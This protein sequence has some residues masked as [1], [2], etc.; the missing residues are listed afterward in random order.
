MNEDAAIRSK[1]KE[2]AFV[3]RDC[4]PGSWERSLALANLQLTTML[5]NSAT[6]LTNLQL[7]TLRANSAI[8]CGEDES[9]S[10]IPI[11]MYPPG[12][13]LVIAEAQRLMDLKQIAPGTLLERLGRICAPG[14]TIVYED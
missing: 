1:A 11:K 14:T 8:A 6:A 12:A 9:T 13:D 10:T 7:A 5:A 4:Y 3:A 2:L